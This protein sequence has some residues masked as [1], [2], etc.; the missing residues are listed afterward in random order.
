MSKIKPKQTIASFMNAV[1]AKVS[2]QK[3]QPSSNKSV[4]VRS[5]RSPPNSR[6]GP[7]R[8]SSTVNSGA[9][10]R[11]KQVIAEDEYIAEVNGSVG[12]ATTQYNVN[13][14]QS[15]TFPWGYK[16]AALYEKYDF[17]YIEFYY[18]REV[19]EF[20]ANGQTGKVMLSFDY[21]ASDSPPTSKQQVEDTNPH[22][23]GMPCSKLY[24]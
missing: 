17:D 11:L 1:R 4:V 16:I 18:K 13:I 2:K 6:Q 3:Q 8:L 7:L 24:V 14:G 21:D 20:A 12:F 23:D 19:S 9:T 15:A 22:I 5:T 10:N